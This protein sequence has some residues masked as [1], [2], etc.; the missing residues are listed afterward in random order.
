MPRTIRYSRKVGERVGKRI[1]KHYPITTK[2]NGS[3][4]YA[5]NYPIRV[6]RLYAFDCTSIPISTTPFDPITRRGHSVNLSGVRVLMTVQNTSN[7]RVIMNYALVSMKNSRGGAVSQDTN[8][9]LVAGALMTA[10]FFTSPIQNSDENFD[11][12]SQTATQMS[13]WPINPKIYNV[14]TRS[15]FILGE[16]VDSFE[17][18]GDARSTRVIKRY[19]KVNRQLDYDDGDPSVCETPIYFIY[20]FCR[21]LANKEQGQVPFGLAQ[22]DCR[23]YFT[24]A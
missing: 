18:S 3:T 15:R 24:D 12:A 17:A 11:Q 19:F 9:G 10:D 6:G 7:F 20:W 4:D 14:H 13:T 8:E 16:G 1:V 5:H 23:G 2:D 21:E 22:A